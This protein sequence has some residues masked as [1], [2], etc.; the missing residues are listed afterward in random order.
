MMDGSPVCPTC[1]DD[2]FQ[3]PICDRVE[4][5]ENG[6]EWYGNTY[7]EDGCLDEAKDRA[8]EMKAE[9]RAEARREE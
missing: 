6:V 9:A 8:K 1:E 4:W 5:F 2:T 7:C 3:C